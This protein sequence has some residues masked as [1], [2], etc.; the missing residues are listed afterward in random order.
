[1]SLKA[2]ENSHFSPQMEWFWLASRSKMRFFK[3]C[4]DLI[5]RTSYP[6]RFRE[7][8]FCANGEKFA[9]PQ[10]LI[11]RKLIRLKYK[12]KLCFVLT[13]LTQFSNLKMFIWIHLF[14]LVWHWHH[15]RCLILLILQSSKH[16]KRWAKFT[17]S[18]GHKCLWKFLNKLKANS[19]T[20]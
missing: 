11:S 15:C 18:C 2:A 7:F 19:S 9:K 12:N 16:L 17:D 13:S 6:K 14:S 4:V 20:K 8:Y 1:M 3:I 10:N 5:S